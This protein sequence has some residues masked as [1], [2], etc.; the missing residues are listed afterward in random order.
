[1]ADFARIWPLFVGV[2]LCGLAALVL[3]M[4]LRRVR[5]AEQRTGGTVQ[6]AGM[7]RASAGGRATNRL[8]RCRCAIARRPGEPFAWA[9]GRRRLQSAGPERTNL[10]SRGGR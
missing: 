4:G 10:S 3:V 1:M 8:A 2:A 9:L 5:D 7:T 6:R